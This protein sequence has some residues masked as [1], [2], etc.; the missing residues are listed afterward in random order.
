MQV[1][2][3]RSFM[4]SAKWKSL[5]KAADKLNLSQ[6]ALSKHI[7]Q[8]EAA[9]DV[10]LFRRTAA[11]VALTEAGSRFMEKIIPVL[12]SLETIEAEMRQYAA[13]P[14]YTLGSLPGIVTHLLP[15]RLRDYHAS[16]YP[17]TVKV[18][19]TSIELREEMQEGVL[20]AALMDA[21]FVGGR[22]WSKELFTEGSIA[23][24]P[25]GHTLRGRNTLSL[26]ELK[27][28]LFV[29]ATQKCETHTQFRT[30]AENYGYRPDIKLEVDENNEFL[31]NVAVG[32]GIT[33]L[34]ELFR[35]EAEL[36]GLH[37]VPLAVPELR[38][39]VVL[40]ARTADIGSKLYRMLSDKP[41][42]T[43]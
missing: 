25:E 23:I 32:T 4:E 39:T 31:L 6:P 19:Q 9:Y 22:L 43:A 2:W 16:G 3:F 34:P 30:V 13:G 40:A 27:D 20:D 10:E 36:L 24:L 1:E 8:L 41:I 28:E 12:Q 7:R 17:I 5:S 35:A 26:E 38:R 15:G 33:V 29:F 11:G 21:A 18:R 37:A 14:G 42:P